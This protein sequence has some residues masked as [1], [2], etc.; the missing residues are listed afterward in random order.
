MA[1]ISGLLPASGAI[2]DRVSFDYQSRLV[3]RDGLEVVLESSFRVVTDAVE[4][5]IDPEDL[6]TVTPLLSL[7]HDELVTALISERSELSLAF[8]SGTLLTAP[9]DEQYESWHLV[10]ADG[11]M[12]IA[13]P[14]GAIAVFPAQ[15]PETG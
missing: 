7:L 12:A 15:V 3:F 10:H 2:V 4:H 9:P 6:R 5:L 14:G 8:A 1:D 11:R 13:M